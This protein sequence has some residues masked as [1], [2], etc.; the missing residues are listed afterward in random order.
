VNAGVRQHDVIL[1][2]TIRIWMVCDA[3]LRFPSP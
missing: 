2:R 3:Y 1:L